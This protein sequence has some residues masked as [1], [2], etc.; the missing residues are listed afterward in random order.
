[1]GKDILTVGYEIPGRSDN[2][3]YFRSNKS[4]ADSDIVVF[5]TD[6]P[7]TSYSDS[8][9][10]GLRSYT[11]SGSAQYKTDSA[12]WRK[13]LDDALGTGKTVFLFMEEKKSFYLATGTS[14]YKNAR[15]TVR[16][17]EDYHNY[18]FL[19]VKI[20]SIISA[21]GNQIEFTNKPVFADF[22]KSF[23]DEMEYRS[24]LQDVPETADILFTTKDKSRVLGA[25]FKVGQGYLVTLPYIDYDYDEFVKTKTDKSGKE[26]SFWTPVAIEFGNKL[27]GQLLHIDGS[28]RKATESTPPPEWVPDKKY[29]TKKEDV[30]T[31][32]KAKEVDKIL[33]AQQKIS[34]IDSDLAE[35]NI[36]RGLLYEQGK[37]LEAAVT[38]ALELLGYS[39]EGY[40]DGVLELDQVIISPEGYRYVG[41][42]EG[43]DNKDIDITKF[44]QLTESLS[45]DFA[46]EEVPE[47]A[48][49]ILFGNPQRLLAPDERTLDFTKKCKIG[50]D[51][52]KI[53]LIKT[54]DL[55]NVAKYL[56]ENTDKAFQKKCRTAI[57]SGLGTVVTFPEPK[58]TKKSK[59]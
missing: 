12:H 10:R 19:P 17:V 26:Q 43:K 6:T 1:M 54:V 47:K 48:F 16:H 5:C 4:L 39:T 27:V 59:Q 49:G 24:Y 2:F 55:Y 23:K 42:C 38:K 22:F 52:E 44:R 37:P 7:V 41:E 30:L 33:A 9:Y 29:Q 58:P 31:S 34:E 18:G 8:E 36:L 46:R 50:A 11:D 40:D 57:H 32:L 35:E 3:V 51:R 21:K 14:E 53:G 45:A 28:L 13:E 25:V 15:T 56:S 20:G